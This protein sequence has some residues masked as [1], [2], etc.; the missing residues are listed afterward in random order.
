MDIPKSHPRYK[1]LLN[2]EK[3]VEALDRGILAKAG[4]IA[5]GRGETFDYLIGER[6]TD[7]ALR[8]IKTAAAILVLAENPVISVNGNTVALAR[9]EIVKL[10]EE[11]N[12]KI[13]VNLFYRSE[14][15]LRKI[16]EFFEENPVIREKI[17]SGRIKILGI[18]DANKQIPN[19]ES[20]RGRV[21][22]EGIYSAD[23]ILVPLEDGDRTEALVK[24]GKKVIS[25]DLNPLSRTAQQSTVTIVD[26]L[27][28][29][30]PLLRK[31]VR[32]YKNLDREELQRIVKEFDNKE[33]LKN[34]LN[35]ICN[36]LKNLQS[37]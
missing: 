15:R 9:E 22:Q 20:A 28:R 8:A 16:K 7:I 33:N 13:E 29:C 30:L 34:M 17:K 31:Y 10:A 14:E 32:D 37:T 3:I 6:T 23:V 18:E 12:G 5:H 35:H 21:S 25:I 4:L 2:R 26:E 27:T 36:R 11:L 1:S 24:M 19:L